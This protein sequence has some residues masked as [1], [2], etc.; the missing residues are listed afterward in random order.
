M[1]LSVRPTVA[2]VTILMSLS[3]R[4]TVAEV[5]ILMSLSIRPTVLDVAKSPEFQQYLEPYARRFALSR[6][7]LGRS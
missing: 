5:T 3:V 6:L 4:L 1:S 7:M 2:E